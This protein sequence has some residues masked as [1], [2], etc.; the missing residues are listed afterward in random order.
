MCFPVDIMSWAV[1]WGGEEK[2]GSLSG[3]QNRMTTA[4]KFSLLMVFNRDT[5]CWH[6][7][8]KAS[9]SGF[10]PRKEGNG[11]ALLNTVT[12]KFGVYHC[13]HSGPKRQ[14]I[15]QEELPGSYPTPHHPP[16]PAPQFPLL[17]CPWLPVS[18]KQSNSR[19][20]GA[21]LLL[22]PFSPWPTI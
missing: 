6:S 16:L 10:N 2:G 9:C 21:C 12:I 5:G 8:Y 15:Q 20:E 17:L 4:S 18:R 7:I 11:E 22:H 3:T 14:L 19:R 13:F 1:A